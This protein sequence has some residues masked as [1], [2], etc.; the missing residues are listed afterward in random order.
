MESDHHDVALLQTIF[1]NIIP[2]IA[3]GKILSYKLHIIYIASYQQQPSLSPY[4]LIPNS[5]KSKVQEAVDV[6]A[7]HHRTGGAPSLFCAVPA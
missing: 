1:R 4:Q 7:G 5:P 2:A 6:G 3:I